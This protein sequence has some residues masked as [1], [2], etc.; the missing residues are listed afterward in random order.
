MEHGFEI[1]RA[2]WKDTFEWYSALI[3]VK[4]YLLI[5]VN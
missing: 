4:S 1:R 2:E 5:W 3:E